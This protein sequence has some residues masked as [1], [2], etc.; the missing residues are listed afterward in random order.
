MVTD[1]ERDCFLNL[2]GFLHAI[3]QKENKPA[4]NKSPHLRDLGARQL[5]FEDD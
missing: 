1:K 2:S 5:E 4:E 3:T